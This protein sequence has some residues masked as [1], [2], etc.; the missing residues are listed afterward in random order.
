MERDMYRIQESN[1]DINK[2]FVLAEL[3]DEGVLVHH[4][5]IEKLNKKHGCNICPIMVGMLYSDDYDKAVDYISDEI[6]RVTGIRPRNLGCILGK[7]KGR[8]LPE[9]IITS[10]IAILDVHPKNI[11]NKEI[12]GMDDPLL[13]SILKIYEDINGVRLNI[14][15]GK[16]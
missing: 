5:N 4:K 6:V 11:A 8:Q 10:R 15:K 7:G 2:L 16:K 9:K 12:P 13:K 1:F 3:Y 14:K